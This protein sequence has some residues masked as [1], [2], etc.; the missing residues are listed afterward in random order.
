MMHLQL[1]WGRSFLCLSAGPTLASILVAVSEH[2]IFTP[3]LKVAIESEDLWNDVVALY[4]KGVEVCITL[5]N[6]PAIDIGGVIRQVYSSVF[7]EF[8]TNKFFQLF[9]GPINYLRPACT[10]DA[11]SSGLLKLLGKMVAHSICQDGVGFPT[12]HPPAMPT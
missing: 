6:Q 1:H 5:D 10:A 11:R 4:K 7:T 12:Y 8:P 3:K 9:D 2:Y